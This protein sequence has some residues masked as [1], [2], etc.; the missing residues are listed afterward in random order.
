MYIYAMGAMRIQCRLRNGR[1]LIVIG[2]YSH[3]ANRIS[4]TFFI[5]K[6]ILSLFSKNAHKHTRKENTLNVGIV[7]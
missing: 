3:I 6:K 1:D 7:K 4:N 5:K 2:V